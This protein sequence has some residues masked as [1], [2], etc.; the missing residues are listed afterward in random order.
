M[1]IFPSDQVAVV[2]VRSLAT[3][4]P[5][6]REYGAATYRNPKRNSNYSH[7]RARFHNNES[8]WRLRVVAGNKSTKRSA[9]KSVKYPRRK[10]ESKSL[11]TKDARSRCCRYR[12][13]ELGR[14]RRVPGKWFIPAA[15]GL[16]RARSPRFVSADRPR[17]FRRERAR[18]RDRSNDETLFPPGGCEIVPRRRVTCVAKRPTSPMCVET[19]QVIAIGGGNICAH[20]QNTHTQT[21]RDLKLDFVQNNVDFISRRARAKKVYGIEP[22]VEQTSQRNTRTCRLSIFARCFLRE[23]L[24]F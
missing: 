20:T 2:V 4:T 11:R 24:T 10:R 18:D 3:S 22:A 5:R 7:A 19:I 13:L 12:N 9:Y 21:E 16:R 17:S 23:R 8:P 6:P 1:A 14:P 15:P